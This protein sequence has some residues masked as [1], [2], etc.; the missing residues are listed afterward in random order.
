MDSKPLTK[1]QKDN[2]RRKKVVRKI[3]KGEYGECKKTIQAYSDAK[4]E[5][6]KVDGPLKRKRQ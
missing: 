5:A 1:T 2:L 6:E 3:Q 4:K